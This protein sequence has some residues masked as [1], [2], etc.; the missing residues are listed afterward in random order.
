VL[1]ELLVALLNIPL[2]I[3]G[4][5]LSAIVSNDPDVQVWF[6]KIVWVLV[7]HSQLR[8]GNENS[9]LL[10]VPMGK[11]VLQVVCNIVGFYFIAT[12]ITA[13]FSLTDLVTSSVILKL[14]FCLATT[15][16]ASLLISV[17]QF[18]YLAL[19]DWNKIAR[20]I[21][22]RANNDKEQSILEYSDLERG[23]V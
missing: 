17:F 23:R 12:P 6:R 20:I 1:S 14:T 15:S 5:R 11:A 16:L 8:I 3:W 22:D 2:L 21:S 4:A 7:M 13:V 10:L 19:R 18:G 9:I